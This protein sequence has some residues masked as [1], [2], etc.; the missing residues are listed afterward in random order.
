MESMNALAAIKLLPQTKAQ[1][2][3]FVRIAKEEILSGDYNPLEVDLRFKAIEEIIKTIRG[4]DEIKEMVILEAEKYP[5]KTV[6]VFGCEVQKRSSST[7]NFKYCNDSK[8]E[9]LQA[10][11]D[12]ANKNLKDR[13]DLLKV[14]KPNELA[15]PET[16]EMI[17]PPLISTKVVLA[18]KIL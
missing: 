2:T 7:Y 1:I 4:D 18:V 5:E 15:N 16:G 3:N 8:L 10:I 17:Q 13:Q 9:E 12:Q 6:K 11:A 14:I